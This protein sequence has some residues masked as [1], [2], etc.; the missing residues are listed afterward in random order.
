MTSL[1]RSALVGAGLQ[2]A[3]MGVLAGAAALAAFTAATP[4]HAWW[5]ADYAYRT[6]INL[7]AGAAGVTGEVARAPVLVRLHSGNFNFADV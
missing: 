4:A 3:R 7:D 6:K 1:L 2:R 5:E